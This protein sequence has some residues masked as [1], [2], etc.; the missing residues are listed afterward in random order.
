MAG[1][2]QANHIVILSDGNVSSNSSAAKIRALTGVLD[3]SKSGDEECGQELAY[4]LNNNDQ[5][6][7]LDADQ[8]ITVHTIAFSPDGGEEFLRSLSDS[9]SGGGGG[10]YEADSAEELLAAFN[11]IAE[12]VADVDATFTAP[13]ASVN[14]FNRLTNNDDL[15]FS[16]FKP[17]I[18]AKWNGNIKRFRIGLDNS[19][20]GDT[21]IRDLDGNVAVDEDTG[22]IEDSARSWWPERNDSGSRLSSADG[23]TVARGG[24]ANQLKLDGIDG[25]GARRVYTW[26]NDSSS[27]IVTPV[28]LTAAVQK[29]HESNQL[30]TDDVLGIT[31]V[32]SNLDE[33]AAY[34]S[35][36]LQWARGV[37][38]LDSDADGQT[39]DIRR[40]MG[41]PMHSSPLTVN[42]GTASSSS[43]DDDVQSILYVGTN[44]GYLH[45]FDT[46]NG[47]EQFAFVPFELLPNLNTFYADSS[48]L[49][50]PY[51][52]DGPITLW[53]DDLDD[54]LIIEDGDSAYLFVGMRRGGNSFYALDITNP[55]APKLAWTIKGG[56]DGTEGFETM[57]QSWSR[58][59]PVVMYINGTSENVL[60]F[61]GGYDVNQDPVEDSSDRTQ[62]ADSTGNGIYIVRAET[63]ELLWSGL[64]VRGGT[65]RFNDMDYGFNAPVRALDMNRDGYVDQLYA[66]DA[67]GQ[68]WRFD[69]PALHDGSDD[70]VSG[71]VIAELSDTGDSNHRRFYNEPDVSLIEDGT[72]RYL[73]VSIGSGWRAD[74]LDEIVQDR[75]YVIR[76]YSV[77][78]AP[79]FYGKQTG[80]SSRS[81]PIEESDLIN[82]TSTANPLTN[83]YGWYLE[84]ENVGEKVLGSSVTFGGNVIFSAY[85][86]TEQYNVC[87]PEVGSGLAYAL[88]VNSGAPAFDLNDSDGSSTG[89]LTTEDRSIALNRGGIPAEAKIL[90]T[91]N[92]LDE[93]VVLF[94]T[95]KL[96]IEITNESTRTAWADQGQSGSFVE[97]STQESIQET[98]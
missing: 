36:L 82:V 57:G 20:S 77:Y 64:G 33:Q 54:D 39:T 61:G 15:Y 48:T 88:D 70:L 71:D 56:A 87:S 85:V 1:S 17:E 4:W 97:H 29:L 30:L 42:Y 16:L 35:S 19:G 84:L 63:G 27:E 32:K 43:E 9:S 52:L 45:A 38:V 91:E 2:C 50:R 23:N 10:A 22:L 66:A 14:Q 86:P 76:Q 78:S 40:Q 67:G 31:G 11:N 58:L 28:D 93:P 59:S 26:V 53:R 8:E 68:L 79:D 37:D 62:S 60:V 95:E 3:C 13:A 90:I 75:F 72:D 65:A 89:E 21:A 51:G 24:A 6:D 73:T 94:G 7:S 44:E 12:A 81:T 96:D 41:D 98:E 18:S 46:S 69:I 25:I 55:D 49:T 34:K 80:R 83:E 92:P 74:P 47:E 5:S